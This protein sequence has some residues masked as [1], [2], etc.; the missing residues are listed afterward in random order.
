LLGR[1]F[2]QRQTVLIIYAWSAALAL[3]GYAVRY[4]PGYMRFA[5]LAALLAVTAFMAHWLGLFEAAHRH[6]ED[7]PDEAPCGS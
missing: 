6:D 2:D 5:A 4:S 3:G 1:G 7:D